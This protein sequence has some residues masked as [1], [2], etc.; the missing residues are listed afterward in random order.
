MSIK[1]YKAML[2][3][4][5]VDGTFTRNITERRF[6]ELPTGDV[7]IR[8]HYSSL[9]YKDVLSA[10]GNRGITKTY[11]H[12]P[13]IDAAGVVEE[14]IAEGFRPGDAVIVTGY[15]LGMNTPGGLGEYV[16][17]PAEWVL[18]LPNGL[19]PRQ[20]MIFGTPG[21]TAAL[22]L[23]ALDDACIPPDKGKV[24]VTGATGGVGSL[25]V[26]LLSEVGYSVTAVTG[27]EDKHAFLR[28]L[29]AKEILP[30]DAILAASNHMLLK[31]TWAA[32]IDT[33]GGKY[34]DS[35]LRATSYGGVVTTCGMV[36]SPRLD[37]NVFPFI[38][39]G[40]R[41]QGIDS[42]LCPMAIRRDIWNWLAETCIPERLEELAIECNL[43]NLEE[44]IERMLQGGLSG[45]VVVPMIETKEST[46]K[47]T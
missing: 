33:V 39:R 42:A 9:N 32:V 15:D 43:E 17:V 38:L 28:N 47:A 22:S 27:K 44:P 13:G 12:T 6:D 1:T 37:T 8:V 5:S 18:L 14:S 31:G 23:R 4:E 29:G 19:S 46:N 40:I 10:T 41:L 30:R 20:S 11:P 21:L 34:L 3:T 7:L 45:R 25:A 24:L 2:I 16:R 26:L 35:A 36:A